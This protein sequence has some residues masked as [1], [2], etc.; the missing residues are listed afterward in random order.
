MAISNCYVSSPEGTQTILNWDNWHNRRWAESE[1]RTFTWWEL[2]CVL[3]ILRLIDMRR[4]S[5]GM[6]STSQAVHAFDMDILDRGCKNCDSMSR[7][8]NYLHK[9][10]IRT[11]DLGTIRAIRSSRSQDMPRYWRHLQRGPPRF[12][13]LQTWQRSFSPFQKLHGLLQIRL[14]S[15]D[16][17]YSFF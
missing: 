10:Y 1:R 8:P 9:W 2:R 13:G 15:P 12:D 14:G 16:A 5:C 17:P 6:S 11:A 3:N 7:N 4:W